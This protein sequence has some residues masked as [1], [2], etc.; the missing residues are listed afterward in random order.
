MMIFGMELKT[1][2]EPKLDSNEALKVTSQTY[3]FKYAKRSKC[4]SKLTVSHACQSP[5]TTHQSSDYYYLLFWS[6]II[7]ANHFLISSHIQ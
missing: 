6:T 3:C 4:Y 2:L 7:S 1:T 5:H